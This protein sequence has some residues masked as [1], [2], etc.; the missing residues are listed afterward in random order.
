M[1]A[2]PDLAKI[3]VGATGAKR[4][5]GCQQQQQQQHVLKAQMTDEEMALDQVRANIAVPF[6]YWYNRGRPVLR[7]IMLR[8]VG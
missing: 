8:K 5:R 6:A 1:G 4:G 7:N 3:N 2:R